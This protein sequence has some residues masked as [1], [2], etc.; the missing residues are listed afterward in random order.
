MKPC[1]M[2]EKSNTHKC[3]M[4][5]DR[6]EPALFQITT[7]NGGTEWYC[8]DC[9]KALRLSQALMGM[10]KAMCKEGRQ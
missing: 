4:Y 5:G 7:R 2:P 10:A 9:A 6:C 3:C 1:D 8:S